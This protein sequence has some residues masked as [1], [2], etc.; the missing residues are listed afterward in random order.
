MALITGLLIELILLQDRLVV[1]PA[2]VTAADADTAAVVLEAE[3]EAIGML[4]PSKLSSPFM[5]S[6]LIFSIQ[7]KSETSAAP[8]MFG[9]VESAPIDIPTIDARSSNASLLAVKSTTSSLV[10]PVG[11]LFVP[12]EVT[13]DWPPLLFI[14]CMD[15]IFEIVDAI[16]D[17]ELEEENEEVVDDLEAILWPEDPEIP[18][19]E[20]GELM[21][22]SDTL[23]LLLLLPIM[24]LLLLL[25][26][27]VVKTGS[28]PVKDVVS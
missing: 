15:E 7:S 12:L 20:P 9:T 11:G 19:E 10:A 26:V 24:V 17:V 25:L 1:R 18:E 27:L 5:L 14:W 8:S 22:K 6:G 2:N 4:I 3:A 16:P 21:F 23:L 13:S 28:R